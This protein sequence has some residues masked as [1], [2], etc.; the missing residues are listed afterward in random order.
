MQRF[1]AVALT[2]ASLVLVG[3]TPAT[4]ED[5]TRSILSRCVGCDVRDLDLHGR[6]LHGLSFV[7]ANMAGTDL[8]SANL[9]G[10]HFVGVHLR[11]AKFDGADLTG[12]TFTGTSLDGVNFGTAILTDIKLVGIRVTNETLQSLRNAKVLFHACTGCDLHDARLQNVDLSDVRLVGVN[13]RGS[14]VSGT[15]FVRAHLVGASIDDANVRRADFSDASLVGASFRRAHLEDASLHGATVCF[16]EST[17]SHNGV[18]TVSDKIDCADFS[19]ANLTG[20][21]LRGLRYCETDDKNCRPVT[22]EE[23]RTRGHADLS[24]ARVDG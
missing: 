13:L 23:L 22:S 16:P 6:D 18:V 21:D 9:R 11:G 24:G 14:D 4:A 7:G 5:S 15:K 10:T 2:L 8:R 17:R 19:G 3:V 12:A 20:T 1:L